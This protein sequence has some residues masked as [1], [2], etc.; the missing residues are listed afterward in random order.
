M[1]WWAGLA[2][3]GLWVLAMGVMVGWDRWREHRVRDPRSVMAVVDRR[4][5]RDAM[6]RVK[7]LDLDDDRDWRA[8]LGHLTGARIW[9][10]N[11]IRFA[12][13]RRGVWYAARLREVE[14]KLL[15]MKAPEGLYS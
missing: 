7:R 13:R 14:I 12:S 6:R 8:A 10:R 3:I 2:A 1:N 15:E 4:T 11:E 9:L 5:L